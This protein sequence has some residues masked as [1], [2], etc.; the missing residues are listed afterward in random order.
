MKRKRFQSSPRLVFDGRAG[1]DHFEG[2]LQIHGGLRTLGGEVF[3]GLG[4]IQNDGPP[5]HFTQFLRLRVQKAV[6]A[7]HQIVGCK[8]GER[9]T[10]VTR[11]ENFNVQCRGKTPGLIGP[12]ETDRGRRGDQG[13]SGFRPAQQQGQGLYGFTETHVV[14]QAGPNTPIGQP[15]QPAE[16]FR[17]ILAQFG[18][19]G[20]GHDGF[21][22]F[23]L[24]EPID[25]VLPLIIHDQI[26]GLVRQIFHGQG[27]QGIKTEALAVLF[28]IGLELLQ[29]LAELLRQGGEAPFAQRDE[30]PRRGF[31]QIHQPLH[32]QDGAVIQFQL[33]RGRKPAA[34]ALDA[35]LEITEGGLSTDGH[36]AALG[37]LQD[38]LVSQRLQFK[39][40]FQAV[41]RFPDIPFPFSS[42]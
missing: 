28:R 25:V 16:T 24:P 39:E 3:D 2:A 8:S 34:L 42:G 17:L 15:G 9:F 22:L 19:Q 36:F 23:T 40:Q 37:P 35:E 33:A 12:V 31:Q 26:A 32:V 5:F 13:G 41:R 29:P 4:F 21:Q 18:R 10:P 7:N 27:R 20:R 1:G 6:A 38:Y 30:T 14:R 11:T